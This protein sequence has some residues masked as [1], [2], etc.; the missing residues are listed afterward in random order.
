MVVIDLPSRLG[1]G[2]LLIGGREYQRRRRTGS[3][4]DRPSDVPMRSG[5]IQSVIAMLVR[6]FLASAVLTVIPG[7]N[8]LLVL[9]NGLRGRAA[10]IATGVGTGAGA[11]T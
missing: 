4:R 10:A 7:P 6:F 9:R 8:T 5:T 3:L 2:M 11:L 1:L